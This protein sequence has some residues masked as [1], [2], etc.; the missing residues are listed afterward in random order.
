M[1]RKMYLWLSFMLAI[2]WSASSQ[3]PSDCAGAIVLCSDGP[4][5]F[6]PSGIS[7]DDFL[8]PDNDPGCLITDEN[9][10]VWY[11]FE[12]RHDMPP[13]SFIEFVI[14]PDGGFGEDYDF[15]IYGPDV[16]CDSLG[17]PKRCSFANFTCTECPLTGLG[18]G[19]TDTSEGAMDEDG[20]VAP[21]MVQPGQGFFMVLD[22]WYGSSTGF[23]LTWGGSAAP[24]LN[25][26]AQP[27][28][29]GF[30]VDAGQDIFICE[31]TSSVE[32][33]AATTGFGNGTVYAWSSSNA[34]DTLLDNTGILQPVFEYQQGLAGPFSLSITVQRG[35][36]FESDSLM[37]F[38]QP[39]PAVAISGQ[40]SA[41][42]GDSV[43]LSA[44]AGFADYD[45]STGDSTLTAQA[46][47][48]DTVWI[49]AVDSAGCQAADTFL[50]SALALPVLALQ[51]QPFICSG[52]TATV[53]ASPGL[54]SYTWSTGQTGF[55]Q[56]TI[57]SAGVYSL[58]VA[59]ANGC[60][61]IDSVV[62]T[63]V[64]LPVPNITGTTIICPGDTVIFDAGAGFVAYNWTGNMAGQQL[65]VF[66]SATYY[67]TV[68][69]ANGCQGTDSLTLAYFIPPVPVISGLL[70]FCEG[71][72]TSL[73][74]QNMF[75]DYLWSNG[76]DTPTTTVNVPG[77]AGVTVTDVNGCEGSAVVSLTTLPLPN[78]Q[79]PDTL[80][81]C[82][83]TFI[84]LDPGAGF[85]S[86][87]WSDNSG[88][89]T[90]TTS[91]EGSVSVIVTDANGCMNAD[92]A[93]VREI[94]IS[95]LS[96][97]G[98]AGFCPNGATTL[99]A[100]TGFNQYLWSPGGQNTPSITVDQPGVYTVEVMD[101][102]G[103]SGNASVDVLQ[104]LAPSVN[105][106]G[107]LTICQG[108]T[109]TLNAGTGFSD[110]DW[111]VVSANGN[112]VVVSQAGEYRVTVTDAN[113]CTA[114][115]RVDVIVNANPIVNLPVA[116]GFCAGSSVLLNPGAAFVTYDWSDGS[117]SPALLV[118][119]PGNY[120]LIVTD[121][122]GCADTTTVMVQEYPL[123]QPVIT[124]NVNICQGQ[125]TLLQVTGAW[126]AYEWS[127]G[128][129]TPEITIN[130]AGNIGLTVTD[131]NGCEGTT[132]A[133]INVW[134]LPVVSIMGPA[135]LCP[136][137]NAVLEATPGFVTYNWSAPG[138]N[139]EQLP[140]SVPGVYD[141][142]VTDANGCQGADA[143]DIAILPVPVFSITGD[144][145]LCAGQTTVLSVPSGFAMYDWSGN[146]QTNTINIDQ[147]GVVQVT[148]TN[149]E[150]CSATR[151]TIVSAVALPIAQ[152]GNDQQ[153]DC[154]DPTATI[155]PSITGTAPHL[156]YI[157]N[158]PGISAG[159]IHQPNPDVN[160]GGIYYL[161]ILDT[162]A[163]CAS[164]LD[165]VRVDDLRYT[166]VVALSVNQEINCNNANATIDATGSTTG[167]SIS[168]QWYDSN[169]ALI[170]GAVTLMLNV[171]Q[172]GQYR[173][174][175]LDN[176]TGCAA[177]GTTQ[178]TQNFS[179]PIVD[180]GQA[181]ALT[182]L[183]SIVTLTGNYAQNIGSIADILWTSTN[184]HIVSGQ[185][186]LT[187]QVDEAGLYVMTVT[188]LANGCSGMD[189]VRVNSDV[190]LPIAVASVAEQLD[191]S[192]NSV[193]L[194][195]AGSSSGANYAYNWYNPD[196]V[197]VSGQATTAGFYTLQVVNIETGCKATD[198]VLV[199]EN[200]NYPSAN[201]IAV[202]APLC[203][204]QPQGTIAV[205]GVN[206][207]TAPY[208]YSINDQPFTGNPGFSGLQ[209]GVYEL[210]IEDANGC[211]WDT[212]IIIDNGL[213]LDLELGDDRTICLG[214][215]AEIEAQLNVDITS[216][217]E[218]NWQIL[219]TFA[220][221]GCAQLELQPFITTTIVVQAVSPEGCTARDVV[222]IFLDATPKVYIPN[223]FSPNGDGL[224]DVFMIFAGKD[225]AQIRNFIIMD[226]W[227]NQVYEKQQF[228]PNDPANGWDGRSRGLIYTPAVFVYLAEIEF[229]DG[230]VEIFKG[231]VTLAR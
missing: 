9:Q 109:T 144:T 160:I 204:G 77:P 156:Q 207:G 91:A 24:Y 72:S 140:I 151:T 190:V 209:S 43:T 99:T 193:Q 33:N 63:E 197:G 123:P 110:Y 196:G 183:D 42:Q 4:V 174:E 56:I 153:I 119:Q 219:D 180:A 112:A 186:T 107:D 23:Q 121:I 70:Q 78:P 167:S 194:S 71:A 22:N 95:S 113:G 20:F 47:A 225:V 142:V 57:D 231:D 34:A 208:L 1:W 105:I 169:G 88:G 102:N 86:Y 170:P 177:S 114:V 159:N 58:E 87:L 135:A 98:L 59:D 152:A 120:E 200:N 46:M 61:A 94:Q 12:F 227:G 188:L 38:V 68:T 11:Y 224:N 164:L 178:I 93:W 29:S 198:Q 31:T 133:L 27:Q 206:G 150:G 13:N 149:T 226:R 192:T 75:I 49:Q 90:F 229:I 212:T 54:A 55:D 92:T 41:C 62:I 179:Q 189:T 147:A 3:S 139:N 132:S 163:G 154:N 185:N 166:P 106:S 182:C 103:C 214:Q 16:R 81:F 215:M 17:E 230:R 45:W 64:A 65:P 172:A 168:Y 125:Q 25:C 157:W 211:A 162:L 100:P 85:Q 79:L 122:N 73:S 184:G 148:V 51:A 40:V 126:N 39:V 32:L 60:N 67:V 195:S 10:T 37:V 50:I 36:C 101:A 222:T 44:T 220:C 158:G 173:F 66:D 141:L 210:T 28:C 18:N 138:S 217:S 115:D 82:E 171:S 35:A 89:S 165:S 203:F 137:E 7:T 2:S 14:N 52:S 146:S 118:D 104:F 155:G 130:Q 221:R 21:M 213:D 108:Q 96:I 84:V 69:D 124:G 143:I 136:G 201:E 97:M 199:T 30:T 80:A 26:L 127:N 15:A 161:T 129:M 83:G 8:D 76:S 128:Q 191:C 176:A 117:S 187:P 19:A 74:T 48:G 175:V 5:L 6:N 116:T 223:V 131:A 218:L 111:S 181:M 134:S 205:L 202:Q 216:L 145:L 228:Q 53:T